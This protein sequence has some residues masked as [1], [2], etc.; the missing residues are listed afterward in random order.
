[1][2]RGDEPLGVV[3]DAIRAAVRELDFTGYWYERA[4]GRRVERKVGG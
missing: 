3:A 2:S 1:V 4:G